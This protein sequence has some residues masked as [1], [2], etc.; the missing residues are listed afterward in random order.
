V[1][2]GEVM[3]ASGVGTVVE[4]HHPG[5]AKGDLVSGLLGW[6]EYYVARPDA[7]L[8]PLTKLPPSTPVEFSLGVLGLSALTAYFGLLH[9]PGSMKAGDAV[10]VSGA[11]GAVGS[12]VIQIAKLAG[13]RTL[14]GIAGGADKCKLV[15]ELGADVCID[16][17]SEDVHARL[18]ALF[19][20]GID[21]FFDN[22]GGSQ[23]GAALDNLALNARVAM[24]GQIS[25]YT[26]VKSAVGPGNLFELINRRASINGFLILDF[27]PQVPA[28]VERL[29]GW[30]KQGK[31][32]MKMD[33]AT[34]LKDAPA[35]T[36]R[37]LTGANFG[38]QI[39]KL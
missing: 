8:L 26:D 33:V 16:Y 29:L 4:S 15:K 36:N 24:C 35:H 31:L 13:A 30:A 17:K 22:V 18:K 7:G 6:R 20:N 27:L 39:I 12:M 2:L 38:K 28:A 19:P 32:K 23:L 10:L 9:A 34:G 21:V 3:R 14:V 37:V 5:F 11:A 25:T 1:Q